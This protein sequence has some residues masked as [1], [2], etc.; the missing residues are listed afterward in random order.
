MI[1]EYLAKRRMR[2]F[3]DAMT[4][5]LAHDYGKSSEYT[6]GQV[7]TSLKKLG[8]DGELEELAIAIFCNE[9]ITNGLGLDKALIKK[10]KGYPISHQIGPGGADQSG[11]FGDGGGAD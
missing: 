3:L 5:T 8:Y 4:K 2:K 9:K 1:K 7:K 10:Y 11:S 6:E